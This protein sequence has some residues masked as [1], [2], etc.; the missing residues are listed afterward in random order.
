VVGLRGGARG[1][2]GGG[3]WGV[4]AKNELS[5]SSSTQLQNMTLAFLSVCTYNIVYGLIDLRNVL[6]NTLYVYCICILVFVVNI[7]I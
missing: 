2:V 1:W 4:G 3:G 5:L 6:Q 7:Y